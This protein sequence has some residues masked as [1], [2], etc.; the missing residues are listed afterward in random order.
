M[1][2]V[3]KDYRK[4]VN[5]LIDYIYANLDKPLT[6]EVLSERVNLSAFHFHRVF[7]SV[8]GEPLGKFVQRVRVE[9]AAAFLLND[10]DATVTNVAYECGFGSVSV[11]CR[12]F[13]RHFGVSAEEYRSRKQ[14]LDSKN[15]QPESTIGQGSREYTRYFCSEKLILTG[16]KTM[17]CKFEIKNLAATDIIY[18]RHRGALDQ[19]QGAF[20]KLMQWAYPRGLV[21]APGMKLLSVYHDDPNVTQTEKLHADAGMIVTTDVKVDGEIGKYTIDGGLYAVGRFEIAMGEFPDAWNAMFR[22]LDEY[23]CVCTD[24]CHFEVYHNNVDE[25]PERKFVTDICIPVKAK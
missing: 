1:G 6:L 5:K 20:V 14:Q 8:V 19:M 16:G 2:N 22:L 17:D 11:F 15:G 3:Q 7:S 10:A 23:G 24:G 4:E 12:S 21:N 18:C 13:K 25:H 9:R